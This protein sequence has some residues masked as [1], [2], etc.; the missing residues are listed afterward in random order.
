MNARS[1]LLQ[2]RNAYVLTTSTAGS[3]TVTY[4]LFPNDLRIYAKSVKNS[5]D[6]LEIITPFTADIDMEFGHRKC[7]YLVMER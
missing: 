4:N 2:E 1:F 5:K 6:Q 3:I 7:Y